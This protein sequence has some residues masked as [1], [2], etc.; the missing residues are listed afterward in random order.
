MY[1][2]YKLFNPEIFQG[3]YKRKNYFEGW[4]YKIVSK[5]KNYS[6]AFIPGIAYN[7]KGVGNAFIQFIDSRNYETKYIRFPLSKF[8]YSE[9]ILDIN[10]GDN[11]FSREKIILNIKEN[12]FNAFG[13]LSFSKIETF[14]KSLTRPG[15]MG[16]FGFVPFMECYH[17]VI[18]IDQ[19]IKGS[20]V[21]ND[22]KINFDG[23]SGYIEKDWGTSFPKWWIWMQCNQ[24]EN[25]NS[26]L[27][28]SVAKIP[29]IKRYFVGFL[30]FLKIKDKIYLFATY[31]GAKIRVLE[32][33]NGKIKIIIKDRKY[34]LLIVGKYNKSGVLKA[35]KNGL[36]DRKISES[37]SSIIK[38][39]LFDNK[40]TILY[41]DSGENA[42]LEIVV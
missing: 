24:F 9:K 4:Y 41:E 39:S 42:G 19:K 33:K 1:R 26:S 18:N 29:W 2:I 40:G 5:D 13:T 16:P 27:M 36:M 11:F 8:N 31:T 32:Y 34:S 15:I 23:G 38:V 3:K 10:I 12:N 22:N 17:G 37:I 30:A 28:F 7:K 20:L 6:L 14:P 21:I 35:P 25:E